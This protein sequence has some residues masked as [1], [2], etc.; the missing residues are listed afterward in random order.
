MHSS[1]SELAAFGRR[2]QAL[3][4][5]YAGAIDLPDLSATEFAQMLA[6]SPP[7]FEAFEQGLREPPMS[8]LVVLHRKTGVSLDWLIAHE[9]PDLARAPATRTTPPLRAV[10]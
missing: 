7:E 4:L 9:G 6:I 1:S 3:R 8:V 2:L 10:S 5:A